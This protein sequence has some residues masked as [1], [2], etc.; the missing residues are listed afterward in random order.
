[1]S[2]LRTLLLAALPLTSMLVACGGDDGGSDQPTPEGAHHT[3]VAKS[4]VLPPRGDQATLA[5]YSLNLDGKSPMYDNQLGSVLATLTSMGV[6]VQGSLSEAVADGSI[7][8][9]GDLQTADFQ[10][11]S[12]A[13]FQVKLG[14]NPNPAACNTGEIAACVDAAPTDTTPPVCTGCQR[15]LAGGATFGLSPDS[16]DDAAVGGTIVGGTFNGGPGAVSLL[17]SL[18]GGNPVPLTLIGARI[19]ASGMD[20][21]GIDDLII[22][23]ALTEED[24]N[25]QVLPAI[26]SEL[27]PSIA[28]DCPTTTPPD[29]GCMSGSTGATVLGLFDGI[30]TSP[31]TPD[32]MVTV[33]EVKAN[34]LIQSL[35]APDV[36]IDGKAALS[37]GVK[38]QAVAAT[39]N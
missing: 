21:D 23:G 11:S 14:A 35:L 25:T 39:I 30:L 5:N 28:M 36:T 34:T 33:E 9:L 38:L 20:A 31:R 13:G 7:I 15:H 16:P 1:M 24:L 26:V 29:C 12:A 27:G 2:S 37:L 8:L 18:G 6:N 17:I 10:S 32:C 19:K 3:Y 22:G 4:L